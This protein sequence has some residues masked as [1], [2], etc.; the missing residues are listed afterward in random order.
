MNLSEET[1]IGQS[2]RVPNTTNTTD[3]GG[4]GIYLGYQEWGTESSTGPS[5]ALNIFLRETP[6]WSLNAILV[7]CLGPLGIV[8]LIS[9]IVHWY[10]VVQKIH[11]N[12]QMRMKELAERQHSKASAMLSI[13]ALERQT[14][15]FTDMGMDRHDEYGINF[16]GDVRLGR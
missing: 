9:Y 13:R 1:Y 2:W 12:K 3:G 15:T 5:P 4:E 11:V 8:L 10:Q 14:G 16:T 6:E 7:I